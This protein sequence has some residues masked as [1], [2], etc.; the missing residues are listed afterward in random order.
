MRDHV[1]ERHEREIGIVRARG[2]L[3]IAEL[4]TALDVSMV[5]VRRD[6]ELLVAEGRL[7]RVHGSVV[8]PG[9]GRAARARPAPVPPARKGTVVGMIVPTMGHSFS[10]TVR[11]ARDVLAASGA[12]LV[13]GLS[14][15]FAEED[16]SQLRR[17]VD[18]GVNGLILTPTWEAGAPGPGEAD[19][20]LAASVPTVLVERWTRTGSPADTLDRVRSDSAYGAGAAVH[21]LAGMGH[22]HIALALQNS[23]HARQLR[24]GFEAAVRTLGL[25][26]S[27]APGFDPAEIGSEAERYDRALEFL[28]RGVREGGVTAA[29]MHS[30][31]DAVVL[32]PRLMALGIRIPEDLALVVYDDEVAGLSAPALTAVSPPKRAVGAVAARLLL[33]RLGGRDG[34]ERARQHIDLLPQLRVRGSCGGRTAHI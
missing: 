24:A 16:R 28:R 23:P 30:D 21:H 33:E 13:L 4:A 18:S 32:V 27:P 12:R 10:E 20:V 29:F 3:S 6:A 8:W 11:G 17:L 22:R 14:G 31:A 9:S 19:P 25:P 15:Y 26:G 2:S 7:G 5:T 1:R 34:Q